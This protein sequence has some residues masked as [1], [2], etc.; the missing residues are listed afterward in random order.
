[1][2]IRY[3][4]IL[5]ILILL[6]SISVI[7][8]I[9]DNKSIFNN[10]TIIPNR[11]SINNIILSEFKEGIRLNELKKDS[12]I[13]NINSNLINNKQTPYKTNISGYN[14]PDKHFPNIYLDNII[15]YGAAN[16]NNDSTIG[17]GF[18]FSLY[19]SDKLIYIHIHKSVF[20]NYTAYSDFMQFQINIIYN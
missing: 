19:Q 6:L 3:I 9:I 13:S 17:S 2:K 4:Y 11:D 20:G 16:F 15:L 12:I 1:M 14:K 5:T 10:S 18:L 7:F 8:L